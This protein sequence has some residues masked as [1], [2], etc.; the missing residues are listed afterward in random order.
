M[1][2]N[3]TAGEVRALEIEKTSASLF[4]SGRKRANLFSICI[5]TAAALMF[6]LIAN[7]PE[8]GIS[9]PFL[10]LTVGKWHAV[11]IL[12]VLV[13]FSYFRYTAFNWLEQT[14]ALNLRNLLET[15]RSMWSAKYP[16][17]SNFLR[18]TDS[19]R[20]K[21]SGISY[22]Y[23][24]AALFVFVAGFV[25]PAV[26]MFVIFY[27]DGFSLHWLIAFLFVTMLSVGST[28]VLAALPDDHQI[29]PILEELNTNQL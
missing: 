26:S 22:V 19:S 29:E 23:N 6:I 15:E 10:S 11:E 2:E 13:C 3:K 17:L 18:L 8:E 14:L 4:E 5:T 16:S 1:N 27:K 21:T 9:I 25:L 7:E 20:Y 24:V 12:S 28:W